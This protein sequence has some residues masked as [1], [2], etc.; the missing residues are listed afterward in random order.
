MDETRVSWKTF[1]LRRK[2]F[3]ITSKPQR[4]ASRW[5]AVDQFMRH[6]AVLVII[7][8]VFTGLLGQWLSSRHEAKEREREVIEKSMDNVRSA[9]DGLAVTFSNY[10][11]YTD[12]LIKVLSMDAAPHEVIAAAR[13][14]YDEA[15]RKWEEQL[16]L[17]APGVFTLAP[18]MSGSNGYSFLQDMAIGTRNLNACIDDN[19]PGLASGI[20]LREGMR[21][22]DSTLD[23]AQGRL[24]LMQN[25]VSFVSI[26]IRPDPR[27]DYIRPY[28]VPPDLPII[29]HTCDALT[30]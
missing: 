21:C 10:R 12:K 3:V 25:C 29:L 22:S 26:S 7:G 13:K 1:C 15:D 14:D 18:G 11:F 23:T 24:G 2:G 17:A 27:L 9:Y 8:F 5:V 19:I 28:P 16:A 6:P 20:R 30:K 4:H